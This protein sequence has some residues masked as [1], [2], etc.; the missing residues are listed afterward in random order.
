MDYWAET[1]Q[2]D[3]YLIAADGWVAAA[4]PRLIIDDKGSKTKA[5]ADF[6]VGKK[7]Y[8]TELIPP[9]LIIAR[10]FAADQAKIDA[11]ADKIAGFDQQLEE[12][13]EEHSGEDGL[14][15]DAKNDKEKIT[16]LS[17]SARLK[18][19]KGDKDAAD[20][21][22]VLQAYLAIVEQQSDAN[23]ALKSADTALMEK[24]AAQYQK[25]TKQDIIAL[26]VDDKW[27]A[28][29]STAVQG[30]LDRVSQTLT[31]RIRE[32]AER[33][34]KPLPSLIAEVSELSSRVDQHLMR[35]V[36]AWK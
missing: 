19:I 6:V 27:I 15:E 33:Y 12:M 21:R 34:E 1:L 7:K 20:E 26:V 24:V 4:A 5:K 3:C 28:T 14:L 32:L 31:G 18:A 17:V 36:A 35:M 13:G 22:A 23:D 29:L 16:K 10:Y 11:L 30:E 8:Q 2:D 9:A 25:L